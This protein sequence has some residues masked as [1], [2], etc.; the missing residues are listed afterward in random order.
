MLDNLTS[1]YDLLAYITFAEWLSIAEHS[2]FWIWQVQ[3]DI[4]KSEAATEI[5]ESH[6]FLPWRWIYCS[7]IKVI[8][9]LFTKDDVFQLALE[10][11]HNYLN[12]TIFSQPVIKCPWTWVFQFL[13]FPFVKQHAYPNLSLNFSN[14]PIY[15]NLRPI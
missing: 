2:W 13:N 1:S 9:G 6:L 14:L 7:Y 4:C 12:Y 10:D 3:G 5:K 11:S 8:W 15:L